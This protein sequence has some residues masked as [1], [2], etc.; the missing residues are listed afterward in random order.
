MPTMRETVRGGELGSGT[1]A[2]DSTRL[3]ATLMPIYP[4]PPS[5]YHHRSEVACPNLAVELSSASPFFLPS[6]FFS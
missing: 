5:D 6:S 2:D 4:Q 3:D 1:E